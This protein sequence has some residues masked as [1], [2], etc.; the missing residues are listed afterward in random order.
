MVLVH[1]PLLVFQPL[2]PKFRGSGVV[3]G[4][5]AFIEPESDGNRVRGMSVEAAADRGKLCAPSAP[6]THPVGGWGRDR[7]RFWVP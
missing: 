2:M 7:F 6:Y 3:V 1:L 5:L 4:R